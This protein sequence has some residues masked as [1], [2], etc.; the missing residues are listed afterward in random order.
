[1]IRT[2]K[3]T[4]IKLLGGFTIEEIN[5]ANGILNANEVNNKKELLDKDSQGNETK[6]EFSIDIFPFSVLI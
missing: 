3:N 1:M 6:E 4:I 5:N 2:A